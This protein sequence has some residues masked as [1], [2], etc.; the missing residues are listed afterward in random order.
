MDE[1]QFDNTTTINQAMA[2]GWNAVFDCNG[3][4][5][6]GYNL[7]RGNS[8]AGPFN[9][10]NPQ[11]I[12]DTIFVDTDIGVSMAAA[13]AGSSSSYYRVSS[14]DDSGY[15]SVQSLAIS[16]AGLN[17]SSDGSG[18]VVG[19]FIGTTKSDYLWNGNFEA[20]FPKSIRYIGLLLLLY[21]GLSFGSALSRKLINHNL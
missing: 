3:N 6:A 17:T 1:D 21:L 14:V 20:I 4:A 7:Y 10:I 8:A 9:K 16:P 15:E 19:C 18:A 2:F 11:P 5:V 13:A 12:T